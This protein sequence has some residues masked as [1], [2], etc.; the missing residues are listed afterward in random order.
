MSF[1]LW[2]VLRHPE[3]STAKKRLLSIFKKSV[4]K[5]GCA[6]H[7][8]YNSIQGWRAAIDRS[9]SSIYRIKGDFYILTDKPI[10]E[11]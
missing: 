7:D 10:N 8:K 2:S 5:F 3:N 11:F 9:K 6:S 1:F 4:E